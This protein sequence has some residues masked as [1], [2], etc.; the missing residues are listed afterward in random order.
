MFHDVSDVILCF[1]SYMML[2]GVLWCSWSYMMLYELSVIWCFWCYI[3]VSWGYKKVTMFFIYC[4]PS[5][6]TART[7]K[8]AGKAPFF[9]AQTEG[10][11]MCM[12]ICLQYAH[13]SEKIPKLKPR[14]Y[15]KN[16]SSG[17]R[18]RAGLPTALEL[19]G[20]LSTIVIVTRYKPL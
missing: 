8:Q 4:L 14:T 1:W 15:P 18:W 6:Y 7:G 20:S 12:F 11:G 17:S 19:Q 10:L 13:A 2:S 9:W 16:V 5:S 3:E